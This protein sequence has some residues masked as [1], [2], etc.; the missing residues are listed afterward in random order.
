MR[1]EKQ[2]SDDEFQI[3]DLAFGES[4]DCL[5]NAETHQWIAS[6]QGNVKAIPII[7]AIRRCKLDWVIPLLA[8]KKLLEMRRRNA[9]FT[10]DKVEKRI[11]HGI[12]RGDLWDGIMET[13]GS[14]GEPGMSR[15]EMISN[16]SAIVLAGS[17]TSATL[18]SG[19]VWLLLNSPHHLQKLEQ[20][21]LGSFQHESEIDLV[22]VGKLDYMEAVLNEALRLYPPVPMQSNR[23]VN[24]GGVEIAGKWVPPGVSATTRPWRLILKSC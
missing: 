9:Q 2:T 12:D 13:K 15:E 16:A 20:H 18:L 4:F 6:I 3:G 7:N 23:A 24:P 14:T 5:K 17:E 10:K 19:C 21:V 22:S 8:P 11:H 1:I